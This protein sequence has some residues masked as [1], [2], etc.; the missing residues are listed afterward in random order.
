LEYFFV[1]GIVVD[2]SAELSSDVVGQRFRNRV[3][4]NVR[5][6]RMHDRGSAGHV[7][8]CNPK[9]CSSIHIDGVKIFGKVGTGARPVE[10]PSLIVQAESRDG[11]RSERIYP[12][13]DAVELTEVAGKIDA[14]ANIGLRLK[15]VL[16]LEGIAVGFQHVDSTVDEHYPRL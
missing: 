11:L 16:P 9:R 2:E 10:G 1:Q 13:G 7:N 4:C 12:A 3:D 6:N 5:A 8:H 14:V 15:R